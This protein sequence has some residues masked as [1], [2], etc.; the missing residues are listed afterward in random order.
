MEQRKGTL[1]FVCGRLA[2]GK[3]TLARR[4]AAAEP[5]VLICEDVWLSRLSE[6]IR[7]FDDYLKWSRRCREVMG[8]LIIDMLRMGTSVV[9]D[10]GG[11][12]AG[13]RKWVRS[14]FAS[15][16]ADHV[17]HVLDVPEEVCLARLKARN[18]TRPDG[19]YFA[20]TSEQE[21]KAITRYFEPPVADEAFNIVCEPPLDSGGNK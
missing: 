21:F 2:S 16:G 7:S 11:N 14:L 1:H 6:G 12:T 10:F 18:E 4:I 20:T 19:L 8:P 15:A 17:L 3:T 13:E 9:L 5:A